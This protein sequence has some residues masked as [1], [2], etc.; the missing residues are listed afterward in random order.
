MKRILPSLT[1]V[2]LCATT[3]HSAAA[4]STVPLDSEMGKELH[5][6]VTDTPE[7]IDMSHA[8]PN[9][10][11]SLPSAAQVYDY[12]PGLAQEVEF[13]SYFRSRTRPF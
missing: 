11:Y 7:I 2:M 8:D 5:A 13:P 10:W 6:A 1:G 3:L 9:S 12:D 4:D